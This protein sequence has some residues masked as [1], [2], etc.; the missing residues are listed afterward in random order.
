VAVEVVF[1][2]IAELLPGCFQ[3]LWEARSYFK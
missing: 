3:R 2:V 1:N